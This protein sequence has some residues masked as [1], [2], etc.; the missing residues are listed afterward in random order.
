[1]RLSKSEACLAKMN[2]TII[3]FIYYS[4]QHYINKKHTGIVLSKSYI[5]W[6]NCYNDLVYTVM[7][8]SF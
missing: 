1:M 7:L 2:D 4:T 8:F 6:Y 5:C 3:C